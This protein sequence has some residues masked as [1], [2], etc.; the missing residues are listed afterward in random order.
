MHRQ[1]YCAKNKF[2]NFINYFVTTSKL[3]VRTLIQNMK[4]GYFWMD[5]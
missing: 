3:F 4:D 1:I 5:G 2:E